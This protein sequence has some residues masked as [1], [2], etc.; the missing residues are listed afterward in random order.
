MNFAPMV[1]LQS[2]QLNEKYFFPQH[3]FSTAW[4]K[5]LETYGIKSEELP[6]TGLMF[7]DHDHISSTFTVNLRI[8]CCTEF[9]T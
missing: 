1:V 8:V 4:G 3:Y 2:R 6:L 5:R 7:I 9:W